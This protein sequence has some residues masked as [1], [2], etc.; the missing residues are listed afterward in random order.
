MQIFL[1]DWEMARV[2]DFTFA[3]VMGDAENLMPMFAMDR[4]HRN[5]LKWEEAMSEISETACN[6]FPL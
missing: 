3:S 2:P 5:W 6:L 4:R 1:D